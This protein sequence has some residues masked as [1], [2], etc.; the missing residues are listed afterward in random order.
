MTDVLVGF[1]IVVAVIGV[2]LTLG[3]IADED[4]A[5]AFVRWVIGIAVLLLLAFAYL[6][7]RIVGHVA[8]KAWSL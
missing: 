4:G 5:P 2:P 1:L 7:L 6:G 3:S 8:M